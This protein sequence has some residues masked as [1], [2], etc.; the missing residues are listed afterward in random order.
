MLMFDLLDFLVKKRQKKICFQLKRHGILCTF[1]YGF[2]SCSPKKKKKL[3]RH[4]DAVL[5]ISFREKYFFF[6]FCKWI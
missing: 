3:K 4:M 6:F 5:C 2:F 1:N